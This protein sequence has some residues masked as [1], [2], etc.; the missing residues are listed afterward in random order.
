VSLAASAFVVEI[1]ESAI[2]F[3]YLA[4]F[5]H[6]S[7][8]LLSSWHKLIIETRND[9]ASVSGSVKMGVYLAVHGSCVESDLRT[10]IG[11]LTEQ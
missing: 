7:S 10:V 4:G 2:P 5:Y 1:R 9:P 6:Q 3:G 11:P 8:R